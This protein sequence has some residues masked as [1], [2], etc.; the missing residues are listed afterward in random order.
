MHTFYLLRD[1]H[2]VA[3]EQD[4]VRDHDLIKRTHTQ[5]ILTPDNRA[6]DEWEASLFVYEGEPKGDRG[7]ERGH[8][9]NMTLRPNEA[10]V[11]R[12][13]HLTP[14]KYHGRSPVKYPH[15]VCNGLWEY[16][17]DFSSDV[18]R[19]GAET[20]ENI[21]VTAEGLAAEPGKIGIIV[22]KMQS[23][24]PFV[25]GRYELVGQGVK[26]AFSKD[27]KKWRTM[28]TGNLDYQFPP[29]WGGFYKFFLRCQLEGDARLK[30]LTIVG[31]L[32]MTPLAMP[33]MVVGRNRF[34]YT[35]ESPG[36][37]RVRITHEW[38][39]RSASRPPAA[40][41]APIF[42]PDGGEVE[43]TAI[44]FRWKPPT[45]PDG[46]KIAD[47][48]FELS[49]RPDMKWPLSPNFAKLI[50]RTADR[51]KAQYTLPYVGLL[52]PDRRY[53]WR[54][55]AKDE[56]GV[57]GPW[58][59][60]WSFVP[61]G[62]APPVDVTVQ[63]DPRKGIGILR[64]KPNPVGR[65]PVKYRVY[66]S[67]EKGFSVSDRPYEVNV[68]DR[69]HGLSSPFP[70][71][72]VAETS[73]TQLA[74]I[75][76]GLDLPN[77]NRAFYRVVAVDQRGNRSGPSDYATAPRPFI[78]SKPVAA[79]KVGDKYR[80]QVRV[81]RS[82]GDLR[83]REVGGKLV[84]GYWDI[85]RPRFTLQRAP[86]WL[87]IDE[88]T[89]MISGIPDTAGKAEVVVSVTLE[90]ELRKLDETALSWGR[91]KVLAVTTEAIGTDTQ[92]FVVEVGQ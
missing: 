51:G 26:V 88:T 80:Y 91:E 39:E 14:I 49:E 75:G 50:S 28:T 68:G 35:D 56:K 38:V 19:R 58:S 82:I 15:T 34:V 27:G 61:R 60:V 66:G 23:P 70:A 24:Y 63:F 33:G 4:L 9:M 92:R 37:R 74:V 59:Q 64:W 90:R 11:W 86:D 20:V 62:P 31:D 2:T 81:I 78:Y 85:E 17:P 55:R 12:W 10:I 32:Q 7:R 16:R 45:D 65:R 29:E 52:T 67:D 22:W 5:G 69:P 46:D 47:Y 6:G 21:R 25:G 71:N 44:T 13:G 79:A 73:K 41:P 43:G 40:P 83:C 89:G 1:N 30:A 57:W 42:P 36:G 48:H 53:Y 72:F 18:W 87:K 8:T 84:T 54:V 77:A 3:S 76:V